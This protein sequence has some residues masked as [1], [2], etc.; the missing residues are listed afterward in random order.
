MQSV[1]QLHTRRACGDGRSIT[2]KNINIIDNE[3]KKAPY[4]SVN[5]RIVLITSRDVMTGSPGSGE[6]GLDE[7]GNPIEQGWD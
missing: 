1:I 4:E 6:L 3:A 2:V 7:N 5:V